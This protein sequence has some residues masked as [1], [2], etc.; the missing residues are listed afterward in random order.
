MPNKLYMDRF[1]N[2]RDVIKHIGGGLPIYPALVD[3]ALKKKDLDRSAATSE[4]ITAAE[5]ESTDRHLAIMFIMGADKDQFGKLLEDLENQHTQGI[6][7]FPQTLDEA[8]VLLDK[9]KDSKSRKLRIAETNESVAFVNVEEKKSYKKNNK[10]K[11]ELIC[12]KCNGKGHY[13][14]NCP[15][16]TETIV[17]ATVLANNGIVGSDEEESD[18][19]FAF[20]SYGVLCNQVD[21]NNNLPK[22]WILLDNQSTVDV[23][24]N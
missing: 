21:N 8:F 14:H 15:S 5:T 13:A 16:T 4:Q 1:T 10:K 12:Y 19:D 17:L 6:K 24:H 3:V 22:S 20:V 11:K 9:W 7:A 2:A 18:D 23:F